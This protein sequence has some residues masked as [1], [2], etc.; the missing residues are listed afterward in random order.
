M[1]QQALDEWRQQSHHG[2]GE[3]FQNF[4]LLKLQRL[5]PHRS[6]LRRDHEGGGGPRLFSQSHERD[7]KGVLSQN[8]TFFSE[9]VSQ[10]TRSDK[11][12]ALRLAR[13]SGSRHLG[14][15][16][17]WLHDRSTGW[18]GSRQLIGRL[19]DMM[20]MLPVLN[21]LPILSSLMDIASN[22]FDKPGRG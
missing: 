20:G 3:S 7:S 1:N 16:L 8:L 4:M 11:A 2:L 14:V 13:S 18:E 17:Y 15:I 19:A 6:C 5:D 10:H 12:Q 22:L 9:L 21:R